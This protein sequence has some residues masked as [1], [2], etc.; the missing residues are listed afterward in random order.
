MITFQQARKLATEQTGRTFH[1][2][3]YEDAD[4]YMLVTDYGTDDLMLIPI[5]EQPTIVSKSTGEV[6]DLEVITNFDR[7]DR[8]TKIGDVPEDED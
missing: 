3:G 4:D 7:I 8:M 2:Y 1:D 6:R 5:G